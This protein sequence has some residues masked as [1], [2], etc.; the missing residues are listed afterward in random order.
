MT[1]AWNDAKMD[2]LGSLCRRTHKTALKEK[3]GGCDN[4][5]RYEV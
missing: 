4:A 1:P 5:M 3:A 2:W